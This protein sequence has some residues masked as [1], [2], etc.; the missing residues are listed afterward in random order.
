MMC[1]TNLKTGRLQKSISWLA[2]FARG[3]IVLMHRDPAFNVF[4][5]LSLGV[6]IEKFSADFFNNINACFRPIYIGL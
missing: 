5:L 2:C 3:S 6:T 4:L 1:R